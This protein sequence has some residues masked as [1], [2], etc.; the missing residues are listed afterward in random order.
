MPQCS[1]VVSGAMTLHH[2]TSS[3]SEKSWNGVFYPKGTKPADQLAYYATRFDTVE[4]D[5][6]YYRVPSLDLVRGWERKTPAGFVLSA[7][8][9]RSI[10]HAGQGEKPDATRMLVPEFVARETEQFLSA[11]SELGPKCGPLVMQFPYFNQSAFGGVRA[12]LDRLEPFLEK[13][14]KSFRYGVEIRNK[15]WL[16]PELSQTLRRHN[17]ALVL[18]D[19]AYM[20]HPADVPRREDLIT[21]DFTYA[22]LIGDRKHIDSLTTTF[23]RIVFDQSE[24]LAKWAEMLAD[25]E[26]LNIDVYVYANNHYAG[27]GPATIQDLVERIRQ[28]RDG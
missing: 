8:F 18:V 2:G 13:L 10:V 1:V 15:N 25:I 14:P 28:H 20:P 23:D 19:L 21:A 24:R 5:N 16:V 7:K 27:H 12:F 22:R 26:K 6:T 9:P 3:W 4:A 17:V 11:M